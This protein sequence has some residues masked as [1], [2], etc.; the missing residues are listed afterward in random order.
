MWNNSMHNYVVHVY[1]VMTYVSKLL[2]IFCVVYN[3][4]SC[5]CAELGNDG[6]LADFRWDKGGNHKGKAW[7]EHLP[8]DSVVSCQ[9]SVVSYSVSVFIKYFV[10]RKLIIIYYILKIT[11]I[12]NIY[13]LLELNQG[14]SVK[15]NSFLFEKLTLIKRLII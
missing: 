5:V 1:L 15:F 14:I 9:I 7:A 12:S 2:V 13:H 10:F 11:Q 8:T 6:C 3:C 4:E